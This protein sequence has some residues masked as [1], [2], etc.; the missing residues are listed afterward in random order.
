MRDKIQQIK[1]NLCQ[2][3]TF[4]HAETKKM[5]SDATLWL[6]KSNPGSTIYDIVIFG[7]ASEHAALLPID[8][9]MEY[10]Q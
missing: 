2:K 4:F 10:A 3:L 1:D 6:I 8:E 9:E 7:K 5:Q